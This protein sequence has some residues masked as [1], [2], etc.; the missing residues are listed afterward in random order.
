MRVLRKGDGMRII[1]RYTAKEFL[2][3]FFFCLF[4]FTIIMISGTLFELTDLIIV[5]KVAVSSVLKMMGYKLPGIIVDILPAAVLFSTLLSLSRLVKDSE[6]TVMRMAGLRISRIVVPML[7]AAVLVSAS[8]YYIDEYVVPWTN[9]EFENMVRKM[10]FDDPLPQIQQDVFFKSLNRYFYVHKIQRGNN[11]I[12][13][14][15]VYETQTDGLPR[16]VTAKEGITKDS[17]W[18][19]LNVVIHDL[20]SD[21][22]TRYEGKSPRMEMRIDRNTNELFGNQKTTQEMSRRELKSHIDLFSKSGI[23]I[24]P[25]MVDYH[26]K[27]AMPFASLIFTVV[28]A[29]LSL[30]SS[31]GGRFFGIAA[32]VVVTLFYYV[33]SATLKSFGS[34][35]VLP[36]ILAAWAPN[37]IFICL[38]L[39][40][41]KRAE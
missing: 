41:I 23:D 32:S 36:P 2:A 11:R 5:K 29:P 6:L 27:V 17:V 14:I 25:F 10:V 4:G 12:E 16:I 13:G 8:T 35:G 15:M 38:G 9:H 26:I 30:K 19:L 3:P 34:N 20:D 39:A 37:I 22:F 40:L 33:L 28:G 18:V 31:R 24:K 7:A 21:G 1:D